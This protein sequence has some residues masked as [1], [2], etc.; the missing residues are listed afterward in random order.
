MTAFYEGFRATTVARTVQDLSEA[1]H[2][3][4][5]ADGVGVPIL[6][7]GHLKTQSI[8]PLTFEEILAEV[9]DITVTPSLSLHSGVFARGKLSDFI[10][11]CLGKPKPRQL[12][13]RFSVLPI[14]ASLKRNIEKHFAGG[15]F[16]YLTDWEHERAYSLLQRFKHPLS[17]HRGNLLTSLSG[18]IA[19][20][21]LPGTMWLFLGPAG[22]YSELH[23]DHHSVHTMFFQ[24]TGK[25]EF[26]LI[27]PRFSKWIDRSAD[28]R[29]SDC[30]DLAD[31]DL[32]AFP[33][34]A[35]V[36]A[37]R[38]TL[39]EGDALYLPSNWYHSAIS[40]SPSVT[41]SLDV[42]DRYNHTAW[43][44]DLLA[45]PKFLLFFEEQVLA[46]KATFSLPA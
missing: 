17:I 5:M 37:V 27:H 36:E 33:Q 23:L 11:Y 13:P 10:E 24:C 44:E 25:K 18:G 38:A 40:L 45:D 4:T 15:D 2:Q 46:D 42:V 34:L 9:G 1:E 31:P 26:V 30:V 39:E 22:T 35:Q 6:V 29:G 3:R 20:Y 8:Q 43:L 41:A 7:K 28:R 14:A 21:V 12:P 16:Y 32:E 19:Q